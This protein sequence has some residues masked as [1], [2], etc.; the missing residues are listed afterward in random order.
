[1]GDDTLLHNFVAHCN[2]LK[3]LHSQIECIF[4]AASLDDFFHCCQFSVMKNEK[5]KKLQFFP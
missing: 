5:E 4:A 2:F 3:L 1:M